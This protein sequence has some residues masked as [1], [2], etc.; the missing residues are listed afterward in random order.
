MIEASTAASLAEFRAACTG[1]VGFVPTMGALH[2]GHEALIKTA[3]ETCDHVVVSI[4]VNPT[5]FAPNEDFA[6]YP[7]NHEVDIATCMNLG[8]DALFVPT[9]D[10]I[11]PAGDTS[12]NYEPNPDLASVMCGKSR[13]HF[14]YGVCNVVERLFRLVAPTHAFW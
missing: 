12:A 14:F 13:P 7:R 2:A 8:V 9:E 11:Y 4:F 5:Q 10:V 6:S 3:R 1:R